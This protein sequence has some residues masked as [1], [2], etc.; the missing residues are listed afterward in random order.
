MLL[1]RAATAAA[2]QIDLG[3]FGLCLFVAGHAG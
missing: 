2:A 3:P 1:P